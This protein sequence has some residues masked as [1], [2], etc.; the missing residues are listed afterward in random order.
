MLPLACHYT[1]PNLY[2]DNAEGEEFSTYTLVGGL[3]VDTYFSGNYYN[4]GD[5]YIDTE[6]EDEGIYT[7]YSPSAID[8]N[9]YARLEI[10]NPLS[11]DVTL[12]VSMDADWLSRR[13]W[14]EGAGNTTYVYGS[15]FRSVTLPAKKTL[16]I[17]LKGDSYYRELQRA[18]VQIVVDSSLL[19]S[20]NDGSLDPSGYYAY[21]NDTTYPFE[22]G[23]FDE[24]VVP[25]GFGNDF[26]YIVST[27]KTKNSKASFT[28]T[29][30]RSCTMQFGYLVSSEP[31]CDMFSMTYNGSPVFSISG[32]QSMKLSSLSLQ[33]GDRL[34]ISYSKNGSVDS[35]NDEGQFVFRI[36]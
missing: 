36:V 2:H 28:I 5:W 15:S 7:F 31:N 32:E 34:V 26:M 14:I 35:G 13:Y 1:D 27:N 8:Y 17:E 22:F 10:Y 33:V 3:D 18:T 4:D 20:G 19:P 24:S 21:V 16:V 9:E 23:K 12:D 29:I 11:V 6:R 30:M 25:D